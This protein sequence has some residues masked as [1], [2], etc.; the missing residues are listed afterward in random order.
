[1]I[2]GIKFQ[3]EDGTYIPLTEAQKRE[4]LKKDFEVETNL[5]R[6]KGWDR[7]LKARGSSWDELD[8]KYKNA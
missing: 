3:N 7:K 5:A 1:M 8:Y 4:I 6:S 2:H